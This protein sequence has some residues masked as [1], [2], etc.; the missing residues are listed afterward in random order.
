VISRSVVLTL[1]NNRLFTGDD[2]VVELG[3]YRLKDE[4]RK[5]FFTKLEELLNEEVQHPL[6]EGRKYSG[7]R[8]R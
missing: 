8:I 3:A 4:R 6:F 2:F 7:S 1:L 5:V